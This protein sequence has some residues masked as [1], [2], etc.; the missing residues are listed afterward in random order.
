MDRRRII[1]AIALFASFG[2]A[3]LALAQQAGK[4]WRI[5]FLA[6]DPSIPSTPAGKAFVDGLR[7]FGFVE[8]KNVVIERRFAKGKVD[9]VQNLA[10][11]LV[12]LDVDLIVASSNPATLAA[13]KA[14][15][16]IPIVMLNVLDPVALGIVPKLGSSQGNITGLVND[17]SAEI[18]SKRLQLLREAVPRISRIAVLL[19]PDSRGDQLQWDMLRRAAPP[20]GVTLQ[21]FSVRQ[22]SDLVDA[23]MG[24]NRERPDALL[25]VNSGVLLTNRRVVVALAAEHRI[26]AMHAF[27]ETTRE[28]G[29]MSYAANRPDIFRRAAGYAAKILKGAKPADLPIEQP[30][31]YELVLNLKTAKTLGL[32]I[33]PSVI[34]RADEV[35]E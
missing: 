9:A 23:F 13:K 17:V 31:K 11:E 7:D 10:D 34:L 6:N 20:L 33:P 15:Q 27:T 4:I 21:A 22:A 32:T 28:G 35:I 24:M 5:G 30:T 2:K 12:R 8:G 14:T 29:L 1:A 25:A 16:K 19:N 18:T 3:R 26:A